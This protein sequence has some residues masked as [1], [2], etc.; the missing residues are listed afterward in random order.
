M[1]RDI[2]TLIPVYLHIQHF[3][4]KWIRKYN[5]SNVSTYVW[6]TIGI[7]KSII[8]NYNTQ[9]TMTHEFGHAFGLAHTNNQYSIMC[10]TASGRIVQTVQQPDNDAINYLY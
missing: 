10:Q 3:T 7:N 2:I 5:P 8:G 4:H 6:T 9:G 1:Y